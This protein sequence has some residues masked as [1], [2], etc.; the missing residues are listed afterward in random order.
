[1]LNINPTQLDALKEM[2]SIGAGHAAQGLSILLHTPVDITTPKIQILDFSQIPD[3]LGGPEREVC[4]IYLELQGDV[5]GSVVTIF[6]KECAIRLTGLMLKDEKPLTRIFNEYEESS[7]KELGNIATGAYIS[8]LANLTNCRLTCSIPY[9]ATDML[10]AILD[11]IIA[12]IESKVDQV[13][14]METDFSIRKKVING[15]FLLLPNL[16]GLE[17]LLHKLKV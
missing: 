5:Q 12:S 14:L 4:A 10:G 15:Y 13:L 7:L 1:M 3:Y 17:K 6:S 16:A 2:A 8:A 9:L 11:Q